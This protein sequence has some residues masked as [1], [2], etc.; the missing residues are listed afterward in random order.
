[1]RMRNHENVFDNVLGRRV[2]LE[3]CELLAMQS[4]P[5]SLCHQEFVCNLP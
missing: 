3:I 1:M 2:T 5:K 4:L